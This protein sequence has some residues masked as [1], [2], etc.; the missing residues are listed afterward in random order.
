MSGDLEGEG[1]GGY[2]REGNEGEEQEEGEK[3]CHCRAVTSVVWMVGGLE[4]G[5]RGILI[6][7]AASGVSIRAEREKLQQSKYLCCQR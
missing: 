3:W 4:K 6:G 1:Y 7:M 2:C 5:F